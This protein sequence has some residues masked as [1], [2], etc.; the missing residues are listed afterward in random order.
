LNITDP[1]NVV[2]LGLLAGPKALG[3][4]AGHG[5]SCWVLVKVR[6]NYGLGHGGR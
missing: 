5:P 4:A 2:G 3:P 1:P 6:L